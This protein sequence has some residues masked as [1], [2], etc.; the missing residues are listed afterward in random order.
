MC[1]TLLFTRSVFLGGCLFYKPESAFS[2]INPYYFVSLFSLSL[3]IFCLYFFPLLYCCG[4]T[5]LNLYIFKLEP[6]VLVSLFY[7]IFSISKLFI[8]YL[9]LTILKYPNYFYMYLILIQF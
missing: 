1:A 4:F 6:L 8:S 2:I 3:V 5:L 7:Q 9:A